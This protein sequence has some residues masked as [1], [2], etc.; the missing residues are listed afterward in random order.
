MAGRAVPKRSSRAAAAPETTREKLVRAAAAEFNERGFF[1]TDSNRIAHRAGFAP[2]TFYRWFKDK[3][4]IFIA[5]YE[6]WETSERAAL[7]PLVVAEAPEEDLV[8]VALAHHRDHLLFRRALR[9][10]ALEDPAVRAARAASRLRQIRQIKV[11]AHKPDLDEAWIAAELLQMERLA[12]AL[13]EREI[14]DLGL[15]ESGAR[16]A[17]AAIF[18]RIR[19]A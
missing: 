17:L 1:S 9:Q 11:W 4:A 19:T 8:E 16:Q 2:Q 5:A 10:L 15:S 7:E 14:A 12:D 18:R 13:A 6:Q 3:T